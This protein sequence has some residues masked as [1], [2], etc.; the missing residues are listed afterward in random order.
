MSQQRRDVGP[1]RFAMPTRLS[2]DE[3]DQLSPVF[4]HYVLAGKLLP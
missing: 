1:A 4:D 2:L 3:C